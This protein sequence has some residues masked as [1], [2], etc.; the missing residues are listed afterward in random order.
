MPFSLKRISRKSPEEIE[1]DLDDDV[2]KQLEEGKK[3]SEKVTALEAE[4]S[5]IKAKAEENEALK[6]KLAELEQSLQALKTPPEKKTENQDLTSEDFLIDPVAATRRAINEQSAPLA[7]AILLRGAQD[8]IRELKNEYGAEYDFFAKDIEKEF[9]NA[10]LEQMNNQ[11]FV[12]N[13]FHV[14]RS[15]NISK[16]NTP[17]Y[18]SFIETSSRNGHVQHDEVKKKTPA[19]SDEAKRF[20]DRLGVTVDEAQKT[21]EEGRFKTLA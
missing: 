17:E 6:T 7:K 18:K 16:L 14:V 5:N 13:V 21:L 1:F 19:F 11:S 20:M 9:K 10:T 12:Q 3:A 15:R 8:N 4:I 2:K